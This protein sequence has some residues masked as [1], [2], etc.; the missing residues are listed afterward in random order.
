MNTTKILFTG[1]H[2]TPAYAVIQ[3]LKKRKNYD[4][5]FAGR[6]YSDRRSKDISF[7]YDEILSL[8]IPFF[9][10]TTGRLSRNI[11]I[12]SIVDLFLLVYGFIYSV[13]V[14][15]K[16]KPHIIMSFGGYIALPICIVGWIMGIKIITHEQ[17]ISPGLSNKI[18]GFVADKVLISFDET[19]N[20][21]GKNKTIHTGNPIRDQLLSTTSPLVVNKKNKPVLFITGGSLGSHSINMHIEHILDELLKS[22]LIIHQ[23]GNVSEFGDYQKFKSY[24]S[25]DYFLY[26]NLT[27][28]EMSQAYSQSDIV[29][30]R[31]GANTLW[32][33]LILKKPAVLVPLPWSGQ[34]EQRLQADFFVSHTLGEQYD[35]IKP[36]SDLLKKIHNVYKNI[37]QYKKAFAQLPQNFILPAAHSIADII[38]ECAK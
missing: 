27:V 34:N 38:D 10:I 28:K 2:V 12:H 23:V 21:F 26:K 9:N 32:E 1:G 19:K 31:S 11:G 36:S 5:Y 29:V 25:E 15:L 7:E 14:L 16:I 20:V 17:T 24:I 30:A 35:Q 8:H 3:E 4:I 18:I 13:Y 33:L 22:F 37:S 6:K